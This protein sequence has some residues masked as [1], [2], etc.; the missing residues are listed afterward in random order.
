[1]REFPVKKESP[2]RYFTYKTD[3]LIR[4]RFGIVK[5]KIF[6][7]LG[8]S[9]S[10]IIDFADANINFTILFYSEKIQIGTDSNPRP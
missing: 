1:M 2:N 4:P 8:R 6:V 10:E 9:L 5:S 3:F 7:K